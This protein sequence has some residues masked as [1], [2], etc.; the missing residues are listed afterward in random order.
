MQK[1]LRLI[2]RFREDAIE[3]LQREIAAIGAVE[4]ASR[5]QIPGDEHRVPADVERVVHGRS[6]TPLSPRREHFAF[7]AGDKQGHF[8][9]SH[10]QLPADAF[11]RLRDPEDI[12][13]RVMVH[14]AVRAD[15]V[16]KLHHPRFVRRERRAQFAL[17]SK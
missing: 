11:D 1:P 16:V 10:F 13:L 12:F 6:R 2:P 8:I 9:L 14:F 4:H 7:R 5:L 15:V 17:A 3:R